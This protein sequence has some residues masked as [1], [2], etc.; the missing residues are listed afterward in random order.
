MIITNLLQ[1][2]EWV[3]QVPGNLIALDTETALDTYLFGISMSGINGVGCYIPVYEKE[4]GQYNQLLTP[5]FTRILRNYIAQSCL[6]GHNYVYD[7]RFIDKHFDIESKWVADTR[8]MWH[9]SAAPAG[10]RKYSLKEA[11]VE[12]LGWEKA[13]DEE[14]SLNVKSKGGSLKNGDHCMADLDILAKYAELDAV[15][16]IQVYLKLW[17]F[18]KD[19]DYEW[20]LQD[21]MHYQSLLEINTKLGVRVDVKGLEASHKRLIDKKEAAKRRFLKLLAPEIKELE[22]DWVEQKCALY[23][24]ES[25]QILYRSNTEKWKR[26]NL[27][28][29]ADKRALFYHK[30][31]LEI[32]GETDSGRAQVS[33]DT[34]RQSLRTVNSARIIRAMESYLIYEKAN[35][36]STNFS[37][38]WLNSVVQGRLHPGFNVCGTVSYRLSGFKPYLLNAPF[39]EKVILRHLKCDEGWIGV[40]ADLAA[41]EPT[42]TAHYSDDPSLL[43]VFRDGLGDIYLDLALEIFKDNKELQEGYKPYEKITSD[44]K[45]RFDKERKIAKIVQ[46]AVQYMGTKHTVARN[47]N[48]EGFNVSIEE[49]EEYV[50]AYWRKFRRVAEFNYKLREQN[51]RDGHLR[52]VMGRI[53]QVPDPEYKDLSNRF[54]QSSGHDVLILWVTNIYKLCRTNGVL[55]RP[56]LLDCHDSTSNQ[57]LKSEVEKLKRI[58][59]EALKNVN[60]KLGLSVTIKMEMKEFKTMAG[61]KGEEK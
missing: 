1:F 43:K 38:P 35:T 24:R 55:I 37:G 16:T 14:L 10:P 61:L 34:L 9:L 52:N 26:I 57:C 3:H 18:F 58:Y 40:H 22:E 23:K 46:L 41:I 42:I 54:I 32:C 25:N 27:N 12:L 44:I 28:S 7:K 31:C 59:T 4:D 49:A 33:E 29:D 51:R 8:I 53:I 39:D 36:I 11:Q 21:M 60:D 13:N 48:K 2:N 50:K 20:L 56:I 6:V 45:K 5:A 30:L 19:N 15:S 47:I 17:P